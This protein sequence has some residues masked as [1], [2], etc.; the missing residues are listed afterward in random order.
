M[1][2][3]ELSFR[4]PWLLL[5]M[6]P[7]LAIILIPF[8]CLPRKRRG[9]FKKI[10]PAVIHSVVVCI[11]VLILA[12]FNII[13]NVDNQAVMILVDLSDST[14]DFHDSMIDSAEQ[15]M[16]L[17]DDDNKT[18]GVLTFAGNSVYAVE[19][20][21]DVDRITRLKMDSDVT[22]IASALEYAATLMPT[23]KQRR[24]ILIS[25][26]KETVGDVRN[27]AYYLATQGIRIDAAY[28][29]TTA[30][31]RAEV[32][33]C[34]VKSPENAYVG[35]E[36]TFTVELK[37]NVDG[38]V[39]LDLYDNGTLVSSTNVYVADGGDVYDIST[40]ASS[41]G[42]HEFSVEISADGDTT[43]NNNT[44]H[45]FV[46]IAG[47]STVL[48]VAD[49]IS[50]ASQLEALLS[51]SCD[52][53]TV[54]SQGAPTDMVEMCNYDE[55]ILLNVD[56]NDLPKDFSVLLESYVGE[57]GRSLLTIGGDN[58]YMLGNMEETVIEEMMPVTLS[59]SDDS[60]DSVAMILILD[61]SSSMVEQSGTTFLSL[62]K[63]GALQCV[64]AMTSNDY[65]GIISFS[66][67]AHIE[68]NLTLTTDGNKERLSRTISAIQAGKGT[69]YSAPL[70][71]ALRE[72]RD[73]NAPVKHV[74]FLSDGSPRD[75]GHYDRIIDNMVEEGITLSTIGLVD[76][77]SRSILARMA[78]LGGGEFSYVASAEDLPE[79]MK[80]EAERVVVDSQIEGEFTPVISESSALTAEIAETSL[81]TI[82][83]YLGTTLKEDATA[84]LSTEEGHPIYAA[85][86]YG[87][88]TV[89]SFM[90]DLSGEWSEDWLTSDVG[91]F[92]TSQ[93]VATTVD[94]VHNDSSMI[95]EISVQEGSAHIIVNTLATVTDHILTATV[96]SDSGSETYNLTPTGV[97]V[98]E[99]VVNAEETGVYE[100]TI[101]ENDANNNFV[102]SL[103]T[104]FATSY[105]AEYDAFAESGKEKLSA[106]CDYSDGIVTSR[107]QTLADIEMEKIEISIN[108]L[109]VLSAICAVLMLADIAI[110]KI[111]WKD[112]KNYI[113][114]LRAGL[115]N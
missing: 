110:R 16:S 17:I 69:Y 27:T 4:N 73:F 82:Y 37:S 29:D 44:G 43:P 8:F 6:I 96:S 75:G 31:N 79:I 89:A 54:T 23:D 45:S 99:A 34:S 61:C 58:T 114:K 64:E 39:T 66:A 85:W 95:S 22:D 18:V 93:M 49:T 20:E 72:L 24:I 86:K 65:I 19:L 59:L 13:K 47:E 88:G 100:V 97:G 36:L 112:I 90:S 57:R 1:S 108:P 41:G 2:S 9:T 26:G 74:I 28:F 38:N 103:S 7:A 12:G 40:A 5:V 111:R 98:Y 21:E 11:L 10:A 50:E 102:D 76:T 113:L 62:A 105:P 78:R 91:T 71:Y 63:Q 53:K 60:S 46:N 25:D 55:I 101:V 67:E 70:Y 30:D 107:A 3:I 77:S 42:I 87:E 52:V 104:A 80:S 32:Q 84:Y 15:I 94:R 56:Y 106:V 33:I 83:G 14:A 109:T 51:E 68:A 81:P 48:I 115:K 35:D 92:I